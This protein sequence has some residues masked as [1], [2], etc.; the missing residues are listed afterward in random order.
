MGNSGLY[1]RN[2]HRALWKFL[3]I[4]PDY[5]QGAYQF[6]LKN[7][8][9]LESVYL[10]LRDVRKNTLICQSSINVCIFYQSSKFSC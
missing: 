7:K 9:Q 4:K 2:M 3:K 1:H 8:V 10:H 6:S 5:M